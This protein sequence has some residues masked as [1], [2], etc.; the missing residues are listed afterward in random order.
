MIAKGE[1]NKKGILSPI[2]DMPVDL[3]L[4]RLKER[5]IKIEETL[6]S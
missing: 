6:D 5:G 4:K 1:I 2:R 3:F